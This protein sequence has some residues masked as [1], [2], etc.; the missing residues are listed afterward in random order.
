[1]TVTLRF[2][3]VGFARFY[4]KNQSYACTCAR[5]AVNF[6]RTFVQVHDDFHN[7]QPKAGAAPIWV[8]IWVGSI[9]AVENVWQMLRTDSGPCVFDLHSQ[10][11]ALLDGSDPDG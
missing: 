3:N 9:E 8:E 7:A 4:G 1:M 11:F 6:G 10:C 2:R 5:L